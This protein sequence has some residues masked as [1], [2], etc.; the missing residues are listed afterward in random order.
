MLW[1]PPYSEANGWDSQPSEIP[2]SEIITGFLTPI[3]ATTSPLPTDS[4]DRRVNCEVQID[5]RVALLD[6]VNQRPGEA[7]TD[8]ESM[9]SKGADVLWRNIR[10]SGH[11]RLGNFVYFSGV[12][13]EAELE[14]IARGHGGG[15]VSHF[16]HYS[17][18]GWSECALGSWRLEGSMLEAVEKQLKFG[19]ELRDL[20]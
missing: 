19:E 10:W 15:F 13:G 1:T 9:P 5:S 2:L 11:A 3:G 14:L 17:L 7:P 8:V 4:G 16:E 6:F 18:D 12:S 20:A